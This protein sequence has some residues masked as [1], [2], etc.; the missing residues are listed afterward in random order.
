VTSAPAS[1]NRAR[2]LREVPQAGLCQIVACI[3]VS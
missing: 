2:V 3:A 1:C